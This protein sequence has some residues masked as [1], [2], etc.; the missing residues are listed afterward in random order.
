MERNYRQFGWQ[1]LEWKIPREWELTMNRGTFSKGGVKFTGPEEEAMEVSWHKTPRTMNI[2]SATEK[3]RQSMSEML[4]KK[5]QEIQEFDLQ[6]VLG[7][8][9]QASGFGFKSE[10]AVMV[11]QYLLGNRLIQL[12]LH[13]KDAQ[14]A[15]EILN[16]VISPLHP[17]YQEGG[18][19]RDQNLWSIGVCG[20][21]LSPRWQLESFKIQT[22]GQTARFKNKK[23]MLS[24]AVFPAPEKFLKNKTA[25]EFVREYTKEWKESYTFQIGKENTRI[26]KGKKY[27]FHGL[28]SRSLY[29]FL[30]RMMEIQFMRGKQE[31]ALIMGVQTYNHGEKILD[32]VMDECA[33]GQ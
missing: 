31:G 21:Y 20:F 16:Q 33:M 10:K 13:T 3:M 12:L 18:G 24:V 23:S 6:K 1:G 22:I 8:I 19:E 4:H 15:E 11:V 17:S 32:A 2:H 29:F 26:T 7:P 14:T 28:R 25:E 27:V 9:P 30:P 5:N